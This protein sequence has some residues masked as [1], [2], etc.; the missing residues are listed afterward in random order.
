MQNINGTT[1][2][3]QSLGW[4][5]YNPFELKNTEYL[6]FILS[7]N[8]KIKN[9][10]ILSSLD[11]NLQLIA[12]KWIKKIIYDQL[13][14]FKVYDQSTHYIDHLISSNCECFNDIIQQTIDHF[15][16]ESPSNFIPS[17]NFTNNNSIK[18][19]ILVGDNDNINALENPHNFYPIP[20]GI[21]D[22]QI[23]KNHDGLGLFSDDPLSYFKIKDNDHS[24]DPSSTQLDEF[25][26]QELLNQ[27]LHLVLN[28]N[29]LQN[30][31]SLNSETVIL[32]NHQP[33]LRYNTIIIQ[34][35]LVHGIIDSELPINN[36]LYS[37][38]FSMHDNSTPHQ[39]PN[40]S[41]KSIS[42]T[43]TREITTREI[44]GEDFLETTSKHEEDE[45]DQTPNRC[46]DGLHVVIHRLYDKLKNC[47][48]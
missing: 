16:F 37:Q 35:Q 47:N 33:S 40:Y 30:L 11:G 1:Q 31:H 46:C 29:S 41:A 19:A 45:E 24:I 18:Y 21:E 4:K 26:P 5:Q 22:D 14:F 10:N 39:P 32:E 7:Q 38:N 20:S 36:P 17:F 43:T 44:T 34:G 28:E 3:D 25:L 8:P 13:E 23:N 2:T 42:L 48:R 9:I 6:K 15:N 27:S 12:L